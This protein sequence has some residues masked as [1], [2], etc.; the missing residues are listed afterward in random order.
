MAHATFDKTNTLYIKFI[1]ASLIL[2]LAFIVNTS[3]LVD[4]CSSTCPL[5]VESSFFSA[6]AP[7]RPMRLLRSDKNYGELLLS[8]QKY[9]RDL[10]EGNKIRP[11]D[12]WEHFEPF[13]ENLE[14]RQV[15]NY[16]QWLHSNQNRRRYRKS[17]GE[18]RREHH[19]AGKREEA[20]RVP[21]IRRRHRRRV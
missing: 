19:S 14:T 5:V 16:S 8:I 11:V 12:L 20:H 17:R 3:C 6:M 15:K 2:R 4:L 13:Y 7:S 18:R 21:E 10:R 9:K 1:L